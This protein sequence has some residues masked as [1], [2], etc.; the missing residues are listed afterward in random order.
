MPIRCLPSLFCPGINHH[1]H[2]LAAQQLK[3]TIPEQAQHDKSCT[4][5]TKEQKQCT[6]HL[7]DQHMLFKQRYHFFSSDSD[8]VWSSSLVAR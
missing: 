8:Q 6:D 4:T 1:P 5:N 3:R 2:R 7:F